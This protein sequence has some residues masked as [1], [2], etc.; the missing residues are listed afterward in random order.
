MAS[1]EDLQRSPHGNGLSAQA[2][3]DRQP[4]NKKKEASQPLF[5]AFASHSDYSAP[6]LRL[7]GVS[8]FTK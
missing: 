4:N 1:P 3:A 2:V 8:S 6:F 5:F 7:R